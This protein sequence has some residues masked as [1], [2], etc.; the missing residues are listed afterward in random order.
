MET[1][2]I[3]LLA[4]LLLIGLPLAAVVGT[5]VWVRWQLRRKNRVVPTQP[6]PAPVR[7]LATPNQPARLH[8]RLQ[9]AVRVVRVHAGMPDR[10]GRR[11]RTLSAGGATGTVGELIAQLE[12]EAHALD[13]EIARMARAP[14]PVRR[15][16][17][18]DLERRVLHVEQLAGRVAQM[19]IDDA[20]QALP[21]GDPNVAALDRLAEQLDALDAAR[22]EVA[23]LERRA[24]LV[25]TAVEPAPALAQR[26]HPQPG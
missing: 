19:A 26:P 3:V 9:V 2:L 25:G 23:T 14:R 24:G 8:R 4:L 20:V 10:P 7:W 11:A 1:L 16:A 21:P 22:H 12:A 18:F 5:L 17:L 6:S 13:L 15:S